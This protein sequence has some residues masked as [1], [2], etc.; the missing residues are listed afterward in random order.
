MR[1]V[2]FTALL[3]YLAAN[4]C[5]AHNPGKVHI[6]ATL[7]SNLLIE[8]ANG[9]GEYNQFLNTLKDVEISY[10]PPGRSYKQLGNKMTDCL[11]PASLNTF[12]TKEGFIQSKPVFKVSAYLF[13]TA[14]YK[15]LKEFEGK[16]VGIRRGFSYGEV[17]SRLKFR[18]VDLP[19]EYA[20]TKFLESGKVTGFIA[21]KKD[22]E[23]VY[24]ETG[25]PLPF[26]LLSAPV[27]EADETFVCHD[28]PKTRE[29]LLEINT[30]AGLRK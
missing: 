27:Y 25:L 30:S 19:S 26:H 5:L 9:E 22:V 29:F 28:N 12:E 11:F 6:G 4:P 18:Y 1:L 21:Y 24:G 16:L 3:M 15:S 13:S 20:K 10:L 2:V 17:R 14:P 23:V 8:P 7:I